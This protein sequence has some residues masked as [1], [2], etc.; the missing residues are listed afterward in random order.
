MHIDTL[1]HTRIRRQT[2]LAALGDPSIILAPKHGYARRIF[3]F[4]YRRLPHDDTKAAYG[5]PP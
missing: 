5:Q 2:Y 4:N 3:F 1:T